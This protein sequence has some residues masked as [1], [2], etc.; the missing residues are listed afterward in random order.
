MLINGGRRIDLGGEAVKLLAEKRPENLR[1]LI[2]AGRA[3]RTA[4]LAVSGCVQL[5]PG[6][7]VPLDTGVRSRLYPSQLPYEF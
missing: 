1:N 7:A 2:R 4:P 3:V 6:Q 5:P